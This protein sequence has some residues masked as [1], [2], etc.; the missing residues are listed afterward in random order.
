M[1]REGDDGIPLTRMLPR[2]L[3][4][5][6]GIPDFMSRER[7]VEA[8][9]C[10]IEGRA[11]SGL[12][13]IARVEVSV[14]GGR[15]WEDAELGVPASRW[16]WRSWRYD[17]TTPKPGTHVLC[18]RATDEAGNGQPTDVRWNLKGYANNAVQRVAVTVRA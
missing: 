1:E 16:A 12:G 10:P 15:H 5:P 13:S 2:S 3:M 17:W 9:P 14:D 6:P 4:M 8:R 11:W 7:F 18:A